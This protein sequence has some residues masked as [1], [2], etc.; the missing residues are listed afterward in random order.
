MS[1]KLFEP[2][3]IGSLELKN[4]FVRSAT[5][6]AM[7]DDSGAATDDSVA[8][9]RK[10][11]QGGVGLIITGHAFV[12]AHGQAVPGQCGVHNDD[13]IPGLRR[14]AQA[15]HS[16]DAKIALQTSHSGINSDS[17]REK[18]MESLAVSKMQDRPQPH[19]ELTGEE[20]ES[21]IADFASATLRAREA[22]FDAVQ[23]HGAHGYLICQFQSPLFN[24]RNDQWGGSAENRRR[25]N[26]EVLRRVRQ[27]VGRD[28]PI[29]SKFGVQDETEG[30]LSFSEGLETARKMVD[31]GIDAIEISAG[32]SS[33]AQIAGKGYPEQAYF[34]ERTAAVKRA[35]SVSIM[36]VGGI[37]NLEL[38]NDILDSGDADLISMCRPFIREPDL[39]AR[40]QRGE[41]EPAKCISCS[42]CHT[43][44]RQGK[45]LECVEENPAVLKK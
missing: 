29:M 24:F 40:W 14:T 18:G 6:D 17:F 3:R 27:A 13:M 25:F 42:K 33:P 45:P 39:V 23:L 41:V 8:L 19:R 37:R 30:G 15:A 28:F 10:L 11:G 2:Y 1:T 31:E 20:I 16:G 32:I 21:I 35:L 43:V 36:M 9:Y 12:S 44:I 26:L 38:A 34:R 22:G 7:A 4:R 5:R